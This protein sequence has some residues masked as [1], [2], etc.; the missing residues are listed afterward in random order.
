M[1]IPAAAQN[2]DMAKEFV[3]YMY[4]DEAAA[5]FCRRSNAIQPIAGIS[6]TLEGD[7]KMFYSVYDTGATA[8]MGGFA[9]TP[10]E[11]TTWLD[12]MRFRNSKQYRKR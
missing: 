10:V 11:G 8:V 3:A 9:T 5:D 6:E 4:S 7:N 1:W 2:Q 12:F